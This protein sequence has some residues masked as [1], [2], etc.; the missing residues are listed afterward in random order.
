MRLGI[1]L[2]AVVLNLQAQTSVSAVPAPPSNPDATLP[3]QKVGPNDLLWL[4]V[5]DC[6]ELTRNFRVSSS[7]T[8]MLPL[9][10]EPLNVAGKYPSE[11]E[12]EISEALTKIRF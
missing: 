5:A 6:P 11:I 4:S 1:I 12:A 10:H 7:G 9:V 2:F 3:A 8:L